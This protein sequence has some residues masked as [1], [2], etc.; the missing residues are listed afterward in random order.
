MSIKVFVSKMFF[1]KLFTFVFSVLNFLFFKKP[2]TS[3]LSTISLNFSR[4]TGTDLSLPTSD[5]LLLF[6][7]YSNYLEHS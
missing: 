6:L 7:N 5:H 2:I 3:S 4:S 1:S